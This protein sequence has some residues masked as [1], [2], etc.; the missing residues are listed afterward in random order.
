LGFRTEMGFV[1]AL[2]CSR[3]Y[4]TGLVALVLTA[5][6]DTAPPVSSAYLPVA[7][8]TQG[9]R[10][11][12]GVV[13]AD[14]DG[15]GILDAVSAW[16]QSGRVRLHLQRPAGRWNN[17]TIAEGPDV[18]GVEDVAVG[19]LDRDGRM[20]EVAAC[21]SGRITWIRQGVVWTTMVLNASV[22]TGCSSWIDVEIGDINGDG[23]P[24]IVAACKGGGAVSIFYAL[25]TPTSGSSFIRFDVDAV[26]RR[27]ASCVRLVDMDGDGD[28]DIVSAAREETVASIAWYENPG[29]SRAFTSAWTKHPI[30]HWPDAFWL[31][32]G[33]IDG[34]GLVDVAV[35]SWRDASFAWFRQPSD[36]RGSWQGFP[37]GRF[38]DT[39]GAGITI[40]DL[41]GDGRTDLVVGTYR[42]GR[43]AVF[44]PV[45]SVTGPWWAQTLATPGGR[46]DPVPV[47][48]IDGDGRMDILT[49]VDADNGGVFWYRPWP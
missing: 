21:E 10:G 49:T 11:A 9:G 17:Q 14:V 25:D 26:T 27:K 29:P 45:G 34:D 23:L 43:L 37:V 40:T 6:C 19:D 28:L 8:D 44:R 16:E 41:D 3:W 31:D 15:D 36:P 5:G 12:D 2:C 39:R 13:V 4:S 7:I 46:L 47:V 35:S 18:R 1:N 48:D 32:V 42:N 20:D 22:G 33:D 38:T 24:D 30:G